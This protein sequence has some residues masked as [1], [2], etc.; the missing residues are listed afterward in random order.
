MLGVWKRN[1]PRSRVGL[2]ATFGIAARAL[3][4]HRVRTIITHPDDPSVARIDEPLRDGGAGWAGGVFVPIRLAGGWSLAPEVR[5][6]MAVTA[7]SGGWL[8][9]APGARVMWG[10]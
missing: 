5:V 3:E 2:G 10:F 4:S 9:I 1:R 8:Q 6:A 7:E